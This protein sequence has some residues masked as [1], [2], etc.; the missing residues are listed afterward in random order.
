[1]IAVR[2]ISPATIKSRRMIVEYRAAVKAIFLFSFFSN[3]LVT[4]MNTGMVPIG[5]IT[6]NRKMNVGI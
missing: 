6:A 4:A 1:M 2:I 5:S 3:L